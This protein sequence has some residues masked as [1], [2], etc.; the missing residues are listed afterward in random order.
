MK[1]TLINQLNSSLSTTEQ[2]LTNRGISLQQV[3]HYLHTTDK[4]I[5]SPLELGE[6]AL[7]NA[8]AAI[9]TCINQDRDMLVIVDCDCDGYTSSAILINYLY[10]FYPAY[11][12]N[13]VHYFVHDSK[14]HG[15]SDTMNWISNQDNVG[16]VICPDS[17][18]NDYREH[19]ELYN[20]GITV[21]VLD[22]HEA[23]KISDYAII[24][25]NQLSD[26]PN[27]HLSGAGVTWQFCRYLDSLLHT[28]NAEKYRDLVALGNDA[29][30]MSLTSLETKHLVGTGLAHPHNPF[31]VEMF[32][33]NQFALKGK[34]TPI[35]VA[36]YIAPFVNAMTRS[37]SVEQKLLLFESM[38]QFRAFEQLPSTKRGHAFG[39]TE[40][41]VE[42]AVRIATN[43]KN[44]QTK[45]QDEFLEKV[46]QKIEKH[47]L[48]SH[49]VLLFLLE[50]GQVDKNIAGLVANKIMAKYQ[51]PVCMLTKVEQRIQGLVIKDDCPFAQKQQICTVSY[52]G[53]ARGC[54]KTGITDFKSI[55]LQTGVC[56]YAEGHPG[57]F[58]LSIDQQNISTFIEETDRLLAQMTDQAMY[59][60]D[61]IYN[62]QNVDPHA[63]LEI[64]NLEDLW[65]K[66]MD[67]PFVAIEHLKV[68]P[69]M[70]TI[71]DKRGYTLRVSL[72]DHVS[73]L[74]FRAT[75]L[76]CQKFQQNNTGYIQVN[77]IGRC[78]KDDYNGFQYPQIFIQDYEI[79][80]SNKYYF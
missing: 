19:Q 48:L 54:D 31:I 46:E 14:Q 65:G 21:I 74:K 23:P 18:S 34:L 61:Y 59:Y 80:D 37:G 69:D 40:V 71:Y 20:Q 49:K 13:K 64:A 22:H 70:V 73:L 60:V 11:V 5:N 66:D 58:G 62:G 36:F 4:D 3:E 28:N 38:L 78:N 47:N 68:T 39:Q 45:A 7:K 6:Q 50:P 17:S 72:P 43:V 63:I 57:A 12:Q 26:Y 27:K 51:R 30:M 52:A 33:K 77:I 67:E 29:D 55:C 1:Y 35:G 53:S 44:R 8:A 42:Q 75:E 41:L 76:D 79:I 32:R 24:I 2:I 10:D 9:I 15:L 56:N 25:N 16:V